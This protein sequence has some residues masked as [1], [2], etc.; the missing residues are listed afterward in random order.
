M[1]TPLERVLDRWG[2]F[3]ALHHRA[4]IW[5]CLSLGLAA[6]YPAVSALRHLDANIFNQVSDRLTRFRMLRELSEDFGGEVLA[7]VA[8]I[9]E[10]KAK[11]PACVAELRALGDLLAAELSQVGQA[12]GDDSNLAQGLEQLP[13]PW[14][15]QVECRAGQGVQDALRKFVQDHPHAVL[16][17]AD[18]EEL[19][20]RFEPA[21]IQS[22]LKEVR[23]E[24]SGIDPASLERQKLLADPLGLTTLAK[25]AL[26]RRISSRRSSF[27]LGDPEGTFLS[28]DGTTLVVLGRPVRSANDL[29][30]DRALMAACQRAENRALAAFRARTPAPALTTALKGETYGAYA[31]G[32]SAEPDLCV[33]FTGLHAIS[34][35]NEASLRWDIISNTLSSALLVMLIYLLIYRKLR[36]AIDII[37]T[38]ALA[39]IFTLVAAGLF[40]GRIGVLGAGFTAILIGMGEDYAVFLHNTFHSMRTDGGLNPAEALRRTVARCG[41]SILSAAVTAAIAFFG[42]ATTHFRGLSELGLLAG[43]GLTISGVLMLSLFPALLMSSGSMKAARNVA[44]PIR[45]TTIILSRFHHQ[46][47]RNWIGLGVGFAV[48]AACAGFWQ[49][50]PDPGEDRLLGVRFDS[51]FGNLRP[52]G[53]KA[54]PLREQVA[55]RFGQGFADVR[56]VVEGA[57]IEAAYEQ[58]ESVAGRLKP[59]I[60]SGDLSAGGHILDFVPSPGTQAKSL[61][62]LKALDLGACAQRFL[63]AAQAE[64]GEKAEKAFQP[65]L[66]R[67]AE[68]RAQ[69]E[70]AQPLDLADVLA[71]PLGPLLASFARVDGAGAEKRVRLASYYFPTSLKFSEEWY[72][73]LAQR[74]EEGHPQA[75]V[76]AAR[77]VGFE[78]KHSLLTDLTA[79]T[80]IVG[81][82]VTILLL[83]TFRS[84]KR[85]LLAAL[86]LAF[87]YVFVLGGVQVAQALNWELSLNYVNLIIF[88]LLLGTGI[89]YGI[90]MVN[91]AYS[92]RR[93]TM[94]RLISETGLSV[95]VACLTTLAG[96]GS[97]VWSNYSG[98]VSFGWTA[99]LGYSGCLFGA[100]VLLP[101][102][103]GA[104]GVGRG[105]LE[106]PGA[107]KK[108]G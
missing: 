50:G 4:V 17:L 26:N 106:S 21:A 72:N 20:A 11:D 33:G 36:L 93:P 101:A 69:V 15:Q 83:V 81:V 107:S 100:L 44:A 31:D 94:G 68:F 49:W 66:E 64:Y 98:L 37:L 13:R 27:A 34:V 58:A 85:A 6:L 12:P 95:L 70:H 82:C 57:T 5:V 96:F 67:M 14:L 59:L 62:A 2:A 30:F 63:S 79:I 38:L 103:M 52:L 22:R 47:R 18:V 104:M 65:F 80:A 25:E 29:D 40:Y 76:T 105:P 19:Q 60:D 90:Y 86:P 1:A 84:A 41:P 8:T 89:D 61:A 97:M 99:V 108:A 102:L 46:R 35:E 51:E 16:T 55:E 9:P 75:R 77:L 39:V 43:I 23:Q 88:P 32:E 3:V 92:E 45:H 7:A 73:S 71:G 24:L 87:G 91:D 74:V 28:P 56:V 42:V 53:T 48:F 78:L 54:I 10:A